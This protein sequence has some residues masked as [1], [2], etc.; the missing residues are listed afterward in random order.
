MISF[1]VPVRSIE[2]ESAV[3]DNLRPAAGMEAVIAAGSNPSAQRNGAVKK[4]TGGIIYFVDDDSV[5]NKES[6]LRAERFFESR[7]DAYILG[8][9]ALAPVGTGFLGRVFAGTLGSV[10][11]SGMSASR[12]VKRGGMREAGEKELILCNLLVR[13]EVFEKAGFF[14]EDLYPNEEN[15]FINRAKKHGFKAV[16]DPEISVARAPRKAVSGF[17]KQCF[18]YGK[19]RAEQMRYGANAG[20]AA[21]IIPALFLVYAAVT[22]AAALFYPAFL[23]PWVLYA[24]LN[25]SFSAAA[26]LKHGRIHSFFAF[27]IAFPAL[28]LSYG[29]GFMAGLFSGLS[30]KPEAAA[31]SITVKSVVIK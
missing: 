19:G 7:P 1:V 2:A 10:W 5:V 15:E 4:V 12:Y 13:K 25:I 30:K 27:F 14:R 18:R 26:A 16:Y 17:I 23:A 3:L 20:D 22:P 11:G 31:G 24:A 21:N 28:H 6:I 8:G 9:P 29:A